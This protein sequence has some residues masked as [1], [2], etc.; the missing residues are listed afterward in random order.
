MSNRILLT[1]ILAISL[2]TGCENGQDKKP[3]GK[4]TPAETMQAQRS[5]YERLGGEPAITAVIDDFVAR[6]AGNPKVNFTRKGTAK[7]WAATPE[8]VA[9]LK[10]MLVQFVSGATGG[11]PKYEGKSMVDAHQGMK[12]TDAEFDALAG[13]L[14]A[15]LE[16][17]KVPAKEQSELLNIVGGTRGA[18]VGK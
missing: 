8:N 12:I 14:K 5:L 2:I 1:F 3:E 16:K 18:I 7:E 13:D 11:P 10:K 6:G 15:S 9:H 4:K 17:F